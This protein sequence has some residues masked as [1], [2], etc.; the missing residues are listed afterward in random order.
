MPGRSVVPPR[1]PGFIYLPPPAPAP[2]THCQNL[3]NCS[4]PPATVRAYFKLGFNSLVLKCAQNMHRTSY[5]RKVSCRRQVAMMPGTTSVA[6]RD[7][8]CAVAPVCTD[9]VPHHGAG[10]IDAW[11]LRDRCIKM[12]ALWRNR[13]EYHSTHAQPPSSSSPSL[14]CEMRSAVCGPRLSPL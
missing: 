13:S 9:V 7:C 6:P 12:P 4:I 3:S 5:T 1:A 2:R 14:S 10:T 8:A 11:S